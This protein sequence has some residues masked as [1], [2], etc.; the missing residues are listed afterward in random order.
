M[1]KTLPIFG[2][3]ALGIAFGLI[4]FLIVVLTGT[5]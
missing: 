2:L 3:L 1:K 4:L 5:V